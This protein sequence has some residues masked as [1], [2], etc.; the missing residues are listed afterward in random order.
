MNLCRAYFGVPRHQGE[1][2]CHLKVI[3]LA[4][5]TPQLWADVGRYLVAKVP[6]AH[7][8]APKCA[9]QHAQD[10]NEHSNSDRIPRVLPGGRAGCRPHN[11]PSSARPEHYARWQ[12]S[13]SIC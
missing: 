13:P 7:R 6:H 10:K 11:Q 5:H 4:L 9:K 3:E 2:Q 8:A 12:R 1:I